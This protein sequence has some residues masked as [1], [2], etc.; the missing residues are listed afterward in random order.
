MY[1]AIV[2]VPAFAATPAAFGLGNARRDD[3]VKALARCLQCDAS[4]AEFGGVHG[5]QELVADCIEGS[6]QGKERP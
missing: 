1:W 3:A 5:W 4:G 6:V 2:R